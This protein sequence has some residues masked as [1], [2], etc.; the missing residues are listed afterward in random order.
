MNNFARE[1]LGLMMREHAIEC[2]RFAEENRQAAETARD[3][4]TREAFLR[5]EARWTTLANE[6]EK[7]IGFRS[8]P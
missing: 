8:L 3:K 4:I 5:A 6:F 1:R 2:R 7:A